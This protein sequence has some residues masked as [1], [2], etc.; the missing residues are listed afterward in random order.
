MVPKIWLL[1]DLCFL[2]FR[3]ADSRVLL[4]LALTLICDDPGEVQICE[5]CTY[6]SSVDCT[7]NA[8]NSQQSAVQ[9]TGML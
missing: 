7:H 9:N 5:R 3:R 8:S 4:I 2:V 1:G 6:A